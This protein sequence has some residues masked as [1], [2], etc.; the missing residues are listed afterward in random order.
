M[1]ALAFASVVRLVPPCQQLAFHGHDA[2]E[3]V[4]LDHVHHFIFV[5]E[6]VARPSEICPLVQ[7]IPSRRENLDA[8]VFPVGH[9]YAAVGVHPHTVGHMELAGG[10]F[11]GL[12]PGKNKIPAC[13]EFVHPSVAVAIGNVQVAIGV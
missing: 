3:S 1:S 8:V 12:T 13:G 6:Y 4:Q 5:Y 2:H 7:K 11:A 10:G 9:E